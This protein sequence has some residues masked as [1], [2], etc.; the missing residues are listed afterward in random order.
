[1]DGMCKPHT[2]CDVFDAIPQ[3]G[4]RPALRLPGRPDAAQWSYADLDQHARR[5]AGGLMNAGLS[6]GDCVALLASTRP[7]WFLACVATIMAGAVPT[8]L[9]EQ[10]GDD[11]LKHV[12]TDSASHF[13][14]TTVEGAQRLQGLGIETTVILLD[15]SDDPQHGWRS[16]LINTVDLPRP[17]PNDI[18]ALFYTSGTTG[19]PKG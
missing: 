11:V 5:L 7:E 4:T 2:L 9:D 17:K 10:L 12:L 18:A 13:V 1:M 6:A 16:M 14:F 8:P 15:L 3:Y 19:P